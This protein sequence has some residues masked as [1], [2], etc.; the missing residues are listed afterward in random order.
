MCAGN[1]LLVLASLAGLAG[2][3]ALAWPAVAQLRDRRFWSR[4]AKL[5]QQASSEPPDVPEQL[6]EELLNR[7]LGE[8]KGALKAVALGF[9]LL[10]LAFTLNLADACLN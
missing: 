2:S 9:A 5:R 6:R 1:G 8:W 4:V 10:A 3:V 7:F